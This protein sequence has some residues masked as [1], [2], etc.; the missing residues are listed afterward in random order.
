MTKHYE[1]EKES[2]KLERQLIEAHYLGL[3]LRRTSVLPDF[4]YGPV[5]GF[6]GDMLIGWARFI[7]ARRQEGEPLFE[8][9]EKEGPPVAEIR[10]NDRR[11]QKR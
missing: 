11:R 4:R 6:V 3:A 7:G 10:R 2:V 5:T 1:S 9:P 8:T